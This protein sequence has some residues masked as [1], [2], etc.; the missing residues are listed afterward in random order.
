[1]PFQSLG[2]EGSSL[3]TPLRPSWGSLGLLGALLGRIGGLLGR[4]GAVLEACWVVLGLSWKLLGFSWGHLGGHRSQQGRAFLGVPQSEFDKSPLGVLLGRSW[5]A[6]GRSWGRLGPRF[7]PSW[8]SLGPYSGHLDVSSARR[9]RNGEKANNN[10][11]H[12]V[13]GGPC[14]LEGV[15]GRLRD[16]MK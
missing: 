8:G 2:L 6:F 10:D 4:T 3:G 11:S 15:L 16:H 12:Y 13:F 5:G 9:K 7:G 14:P 1:M